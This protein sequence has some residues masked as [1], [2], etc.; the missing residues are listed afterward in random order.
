MERWHKSF[1][2]EYDLPQRND[3]YGIKFAT[4]LDD[5]SIVAFKT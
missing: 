3:A 5:Y 2:Q 4:N 1:N